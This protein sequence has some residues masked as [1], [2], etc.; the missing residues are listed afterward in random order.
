MPC[1]VH[2]RHHLLVY[3]LFLAFYQLI[4]H[5]HSEYVLEWWRRFAAH[6]AQV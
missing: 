1:Q 3:Q 6:C 2:H 4:Y 5:L